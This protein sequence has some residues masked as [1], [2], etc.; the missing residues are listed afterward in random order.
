MTF[1]S[2][3]IAVAVTGGIAAYKSCDLIRELK[4]HG[5]E[6]RVAM[7]PSATRFISELTLATLSEHPVM[8]SL[9]EGNEEQG[10]VHI[11]LARWCD[12]FV[13]CPATANVLAK[14]AMGLADDIVTT[15]ILATRAPV[16]FCPAM[17]SIMW[18]KKSVQANVKQLREFGYDIIEPEWGALATTAE[19]EGWG[20]LASVAHI[21]QKLKYTLL[22]TRELS[23]K[24]VIVTAGPTRAP[25]DP[26]RFITNYSSG[27]M[28][29]ALAEAACLMGAEVVLISGPNNL[30]PVYGVEYVEI[31]TAEELKGAIDAEYENADVLLMA[32]AVS[33]YKPVKTAPQ[34]L[35]KTEEGLT[36]EL[37]RTIDV[38]AELGKCKDKCI[39][40]GFAVETE[41]GSANAVK[42]INKKNLDMVV[43]N[44]PLEEG[45]AFAGD[46]NI[47][48]I[49]HKDGQEEKLPKMSK[50]EVA[51]AILKRVHA[52]FNKRTQKTAAN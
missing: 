2:K 23:G 44:N 9:F 37:T 16:V 8:T 15:S 28:G 11:D 3:K 19:G 46:T 17:N 27:K 5:A 4:K 52:L 13:V 24:K 40:V 36:L 32:A 25:I 10:T 21:V 20:R 30:P 35:K 31:E 47:V 1:L 42:K 12:A 48:S 26:V 49:I 6:V 50:L 43:L 45:A 41:D 51:E 7:T 18:E 38:L 34:K 29:F 33:D 22:S 39:H 14:V